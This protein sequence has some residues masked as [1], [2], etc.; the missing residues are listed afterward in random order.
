MCVHVSVVCTRG[1]D[2]STHRHEAM[3][4]GKQHGGGRIKRPVN[5]R[6]RAD[7]KKWGKDGKGGGGS[8]Q[9]GACVGWKTGKREEVVDSD[10]NCSS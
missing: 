6:Q 5:A 4:M 10:A 8:N 3:S 1:V 7:N 2:A 9:P